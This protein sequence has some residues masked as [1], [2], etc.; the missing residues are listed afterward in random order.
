VKLIELKEFNVSML[1]FLQR[2]GAPM[3]TTYHVRR[4]LASRAL[5]A[6]AAVALLSGLCGCS[7]S[8]PLAGFVDD[9][10]TGSVS[11]PGDPAPKK[12]AVVDVNG[13]VPRA[14]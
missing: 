7:V 3:G 10:T 14:Q 12:V 4:P 9:S 2:G 13:A 1:L 8:M 5:R 6:F 11:N